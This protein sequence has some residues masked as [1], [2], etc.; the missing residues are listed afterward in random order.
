MKLKGSCH[1]GAVEFSVVSHTPQPFLRCYCSICRKT[2]GGG[3]YAINIMG[4]SRTLQVR[5]ERNIAVY[6]AR[7]KEKGASK[8]TLSKG[9]RHFCRKCA[10]A[11]WVWDPQ[12]PEWVYPFAS[13]IDTPLPRPREGVSMMLD[14]AAPWADVARGRHHQHFGEYPKESI[15]GW[16][17]KRGLEVS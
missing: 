16:H 10:S 9:R 13:A 12:W 14:Y 1:C 4:E 5:G 8:P 15:A 2:G 7:I 11:L 17:E 3:G 6:R